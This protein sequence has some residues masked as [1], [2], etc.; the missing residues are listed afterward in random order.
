MAPTNEKQNACFQQDGGFNLEVPYPFLLEPVAQ[1]WL[2]WRLGHGQIVGSGVHH[3]VGVSSPQIYCKM[4]EGID[5]LATY[6]KRFA[7]Q[8][9]SG[10]TYIEQAGHVKALLLRLRQ[11][12]MNEAAFALI[13]QSGVNW[14]SSAFEH[15]LMAGLDEAYAIA[16]YSSSCDTQPI[17]TSLLQQLV[18]PLVYYRKARQGW[19]VT[20]SHPQFGT[21]AR[22]RAFHGCLAFCTQN[23]YCP[24]HSRRSLD[25]DAETGKVMQVCLE[26]LNESDSHRR[27]EKRVQAFIKGCT[28]PVISTLSVDIEVELVRWLQADPNFKSKSELLLGHNTQ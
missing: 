19:S 25:K 27:L 7:R 20:I 5:L 18:A 14:A 23:L 11:I 10:E 13:Q 28:L 24:W 1:P 17:G 21:G 4:L 22:M 3:G 9:P 2:G 12:K 26:S 15:Y 6:N 8:V 16:L